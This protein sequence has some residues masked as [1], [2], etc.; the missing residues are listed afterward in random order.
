[1]AVKAFGLV[2]VQGLATSLV[3]ADTA[4]KT[5][6]VRLIGYEL[7]RGSGLVTI[8]F[9]GDVGAVNAAARAA[10]GL[11]EEMGRLVACRVIARPHDGIDGIL[12]NIDSAGPDPGGAAAGGRLDAGEPP[13]GLELKVEARDRAG[14]APSDSGVQDPAE[15]APCE[16]GVSPEAAIIPGCPD[17]DREKERAEVCNLCNDPACPR[18][19]GDPRFNCLHFKEPK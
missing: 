18:R 11:A 19:K 9:C 1:M 2:E 6:N 8:K 13:A 16:D 15:S 7:G 17:D 3:V 5:A 12:Q 4:V 10:A 14:E